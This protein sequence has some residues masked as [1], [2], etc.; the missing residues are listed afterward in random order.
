MVF[1][2]SMFRITLQDPSSGDKNARVKCNRWF[3]VGGGSVGGPI[4]GHLPHQGSRQPIGGMGSSFNFSGLEN[5]A[6]QTLVGGPLSQTGL[7][8]QVIM[9]IC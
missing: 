7:L 3:G 2:G 6:S 1:L 9:Y 4:G 5:L 8:T